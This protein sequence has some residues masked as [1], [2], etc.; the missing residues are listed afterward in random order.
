M[1][2]LEYE[3]EQEAKR[4]VVPSHTTIAEFERQVA[5]F[6]GAPYGVAVESC[7]AA[8]ELC[9]RYTQAGCITVPRRTYLSVPMLAGKLGIDL[10]WANISNVWQDYYFLTPSIVDA[11]VYWKKGGYL[12]GTYMCLSFQKQKHLSLNKGGMI[13]CNSKLPAERLRKLANDGRVPG[14]PWRE[15]DIDSWGLH[16]A[17]TPETALLGLERLPAAIAT[18]PRQWVYEDWPLL[19]EMKI[20][21]NKQL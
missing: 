6:Y 11:A 19:T 16:Y 10:I 17:M 15:Q 1:H 7:T 21:K 2:N 18:K 14:V 20:F 9:L 5:A 12:K 8:I 13:L 3:A 4:K